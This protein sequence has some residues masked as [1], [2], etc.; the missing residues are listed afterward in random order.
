[1]PEANLDSVR[2]LLPRQYVGRWKNDENIVFN[3]IQYVDNE[4]LSLVKLFVPVADYRNLEV[5]TFLGKVVS[6]GL[7]TDDEGR[8]VLKSIMLDSN[9]A[10]Q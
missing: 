5:K 4:T 3:V 10:K 6:M 7:D 1:M 9:T 8:S 2:A